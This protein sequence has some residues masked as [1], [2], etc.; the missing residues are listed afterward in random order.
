MKYFIYI[1]L[2][3]S[4]QSQQQF[5]EAYFSEHIDLQM[6][7]IAFPKSAIPIGS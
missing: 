3:M 1:I 6:E 4:Q 2:Q 7:Y 5:L